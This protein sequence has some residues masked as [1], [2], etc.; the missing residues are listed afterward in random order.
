MARLCAAARIGA[1]VLLERLGDLPADGQN[2]IQRCHRLLEHHADVAAP[3]FAH[4]RVRELHEVAAGEQDLAARDPPGRI[5][6]QA[7]NRQRP[8]GLARSAFADDRDCLALLD[9]IGD[10]VD[11]AHDSRAGP[12]LGMQ[13]L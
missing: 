13:I 10:P 1:A 5:R 8:D 4:L 7:Q 2:G 9:G 6:D 11:S 3:H 12:E